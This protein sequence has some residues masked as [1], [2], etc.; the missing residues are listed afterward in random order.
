MYVGVET[1]QNQKNKIK[2]TL[3]IAGSWEEKKKEEEK[4]EKIGERKTKDASLNAK[5][6]IQPI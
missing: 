5:P 1:N 2:R 6:C 3:G 4:K